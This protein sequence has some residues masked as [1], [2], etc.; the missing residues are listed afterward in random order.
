MKLLYIYM[1]DVGPLGSRGFNLDSDWTFSYD[2]RVDYQIGVS[3]HPVLGSDFFKLPNNEARIDSASV[4][5]GKNGAGKTSIAASISDVYANL[6]IIRMYKYRGKYKRYC[7]VVEIDGKI[8]LCRNYPVQLKRE[9]VEKLPEEIKAKF[10]AGCFDAFAK[11]AY[12]ELCDYAKCLYYSPMITSEKVV[13]AH[14]GG[15]FI[16]ASAT[17]AATQGSWESYRDAERIDVINFLAKY[18]GQI[19][20]AGLMSDVSSPK[21]VVI[22][23]PRH[24]VV[25]NSALVSSDVDDR[26]LRVMKFCEASDG[27]ARAI[28]TTVSKLIKWEKM[29]PQKKDHGKKVCHRF[30]LRYLECFIKMYQDLGWVIKDL[31]SEYL[32]HDFRDPEQQYQAYWNCCNALLQIGKEISDSDDVDLLLELDDDFDHKKYVKGIEL[33]LSV[34]ELLRDRK[35]GIANGGVAC[36]I[37]DKTVSLLATIISKAGEIGIGDALRF[38]FNP[39]LSSGEMSYLSMFARLDKKLP[40]SG[41]QLIFLDEIETTLHPQLQTEIVE[42]VIKFLSFSRP[43]LQCHVIFATHSPMLLSDI[44]RGNAVLLDE[45]ADNINWQDNTFGA[46]IFDLYR[47]PFALKRG[48]LGSFA[49]SKLQQVVHD[50]E[51]GRVTEMDM[52]SVDQIGDKKLKSYLKDRIRCDD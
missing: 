2:R 44:P 50:L 41:N 22:S 25:I 37:N 8:L 36:S 31:E 12:P 43:E 42:R 11:I 18:K 35:N 1:D 10:D 20:D 16:D 38:C 21:Q 34:I 23:G 15:D 45:E 6:N 52:I 32:T 5:V 46:N 4:I 49:L 19:A 7:A 9:D 47:R 33:L 3:Y 27:W 26:L 48:T 30:G 40:V 13:V 24:S 28:V 39:A 29:V 51:N 17:Y 14:E